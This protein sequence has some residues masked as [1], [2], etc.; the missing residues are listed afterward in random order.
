MNDAAERADRPL[1]AVIGDAFLGDVG[2]LTL[3]DRSSA[4]TEMSSSS[5]FT[6]GNSISTFSE[7]PAPRR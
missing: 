4:A 3:I 2:R 1:A 6:P 5:A 7:L